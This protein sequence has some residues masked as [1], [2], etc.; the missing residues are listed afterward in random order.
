MKYID[1][2]DKNRILGSQLDSNKF[3]TLIFLLSEILKLFMSVFNSVP[4]KINK[5]RLI[6]RLM[7]T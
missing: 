6:T 1:L 7:N 2:I 4:P 5:K 3:E